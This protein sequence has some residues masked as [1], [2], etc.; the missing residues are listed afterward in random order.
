MGSVCNEIIE[1][2][3]D[4]ISSQDISIKARYS[5]KSMINIRAKKQKTMEPSKEEYPQP[6]CSS[7]PGT[8]TI[9]IHT[10]GCTH[11]SSDSEYMAGQLVSYGYK[12]TDDK[13]K[14]DL[15]LLNSCTVK[16]P[17]VDHFRNEI[18][19]G[20]RQGKHVVLAGCVPQGAPKADFI[21]GLSIIGVQQ[22]DR[23]VEVVEETLKGHSVRLMGQKK[24]SG[25]KLGGASL[26]LPKVRKNPLIEIIPINT[27]CL[28]QCTY[29]KTKHARGHLGSYPPEEIVARARQCFSEGV[30]ELW[31]TSEDTGTYGRDIGSSLPELLWAL[32]AVLPD[33]AMMRVGM[34]NPP[35]ILEHLEEMAKIL[36]HPRVYSFLHIPVQSGSDQVLADMRREYTRAEFIHVVQFL[37]ERVPG[38]TI[39]TDIICGF[40]TETEADFNLTMSLCEEFRFPSLFINQFFPRPGTPAAKLPLIPAQEVKKRTKRLTD[41]FQSYSP[42]SH[43]LGTIQGVL[44]SDEAHDS[45]NYIAHTKS[46]IQVIVPKLDTILGTWVRVV[47]VQTR[48]HCLIGEL[49]ETPGNISTNQNERENISPNGNGFEKIWTNGGG[50]NF[51]A[52][53][54]NNGVMKSANE[55]NGD[56]EGLN[57]SGSVGYI[58]NGKTINNDNLLNQIT[59]KELQDNYQELQRIQQNGYVGCKNVERNKIDPPN[60][61]HIGA[62][63]GSVNEHSD[64]P[65]NMQNNPI[66]FDKSGNDI[67]NMVN[68]ETDSINILSKEMN[69]QNVKSKNLD[70][71]NGINKE[72]DVKD[73]KSINFE[74]N[75]KIITEINDKDINIDK[76]VSKNLPITNM[77]SKDMCNKNIE[78]N[79]MN[80]GTLDSEF[81]QGFLSGGCCNN[82]WDDNNNNDK[83]SG[84]LACKRGSEQN[85][86][87]Y[88]D[89]CCDSSKTC[90]KTNDYEISGDT[91]NKESKTVETHPKKLNNEYVENLEYETKE[92]HLGNDKDPNSYDEKIPDFIDDND[93]SIVNNVPFIET[94]LKRRTVRTNQIA[95]TRRSVAKS[96]NKDG[97]GVADTKIKDGVNVTNSKYKTEEEENATFKN[98]AQIENAQNE[99][100]NSI[101]T[102]FSKNQTELCTNIN[103]TSS[104]KPNDRKHFDNMSANT[105]MNSNLPKPSFGH[106]GT[107]VLNLVQSN[108]GKVLNY[109]LEAEY[110]PYSMRRTEK[111]RLCLELNPEPLVCTANMI[112]S[113]PRRL[114]D[115]SFK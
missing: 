64:N 19:A 18:E 94:E 95:E 81:I 40:P 2:I 58:T 69:R 62:Y 5:N 106:Y 28:N 39:A 21:Q 4:L 76:G 37:S 88:S 12:I 91:K 23:V 38:L 96:K 107:C 77:V 87:N 68:K 65:L 93:K 50:V 51:C 92:N 16:N 35:Y 31:L 102:K 52:I 45:I 74:T 53:D 112:P 111:K 70:I 75:N 34:T 57:N 24:K 100:I 104:L 56:N 73:I 63:F 11:N 108:L 30:I 90:C 49:L 72:M 43:L 105:Q 47:I 101:E 54:G 82:N 42:Y 25:K 86:N 110:T 14:A 6:D 85:S 26:Q 48:K 59:M 66:D 78:S 10:W 32:I 17:A 1:D 13:N 8:Q 55:G 29:C 99:T 80:G 46:Y 83:T 7:I 44:V 22:I 79:L 103:E 114:S 89:L 113:R 41:L 67:N 60:N 36:N 97:V 84:D 115:Y 33:H 61:G 71:N 9:Y 109:P 27:G 20:R 15:W 98:R 3:E